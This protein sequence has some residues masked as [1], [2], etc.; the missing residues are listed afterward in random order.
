MRKGWIIGIIVLFISISVLTSVSSK[1]ISISDD[2]ILEDNPEIEPLDTYREI[3]TKIHAIVP[4][5]TL[6]GKIT[7]FGILF[8]NVEIW[9]ED[10]FDISGFVFFPKFP[11]IRY[12]D[13]DVNHIIAPR[14]CIYFEGGWQPGWEAVQAIAIGNIEWS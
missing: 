3:L 4:E 5:G 9:S 13:I 8:R 10:S 12:F 11:I 2:K 1:D 7:G 6:N 14:C